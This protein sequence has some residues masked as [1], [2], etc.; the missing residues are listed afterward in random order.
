MGIIKAPI[1]EKSASKLAKVPGMHAVGDPP[2][3]YLCVSGGGKSWI[4]RY[5]LDGRRRDLGLGSIIDLSLAEARDKAREKRKLIL[6]GIDPIEAKREQ[7]DSRTV[8]KSKLMTFSQCVDGYLEAH[9]DG[10]RN[11]KH[12]QQWF[13][14]LETY[15][16]PLIGSM[17]VSSVD[18]PLVLAIL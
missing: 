2:G 5:S 6:Q 4:L 7:R 9:G 17:N 18:T 15:A 13:N 11:S 3:L 8:A 12:R 1:A 10:W 14:T 16:Y